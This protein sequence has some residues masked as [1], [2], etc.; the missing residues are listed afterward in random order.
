MNRVTWLTTFVECSVCKRKVRGHVPKGGDGSRLVPYRHNH[1]ISGTGRCN[2][3]MFT[4]KEMPT[5]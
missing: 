3:H 4:V 2:G 5:K 1:A